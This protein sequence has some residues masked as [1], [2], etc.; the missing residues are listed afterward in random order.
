MGKLRGII[1]AMND[2]AEHET[3]VETESY[4][5]WADDDEQRRAFVLE[6]VGVA[7]SELDAHALGQMVVELAEMLRTGIS[8]PP[9]T[10]RLRS[11]T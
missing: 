9:K 7:A 3:L 2:V 8:P 1:T 10:K 4:P 6:A 11:V 5:S